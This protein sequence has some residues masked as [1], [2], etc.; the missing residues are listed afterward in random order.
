[1]KEKKGKIFNQQEVEAIIA[2]NKTMFR[3]VVKPLKHESLVNCVLKGQLL[4]EDSKK[5]KGFQV[6]FQK[7]KNKWFAEDKPTGIIVKSKFQVGQEIFVKENFWVNKKH[8]KFCWYNN[9]RLTLRIKSVKVESLQDI[10]EEDAIKEGMSGGLVHL[11]YLSEIDAFSAV[12]NSTHK[13]QEHK[14]EANPWVFV[15][16]FEVI[17]N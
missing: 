6:Y 17:N 12:W 9:S 2:G 13:K 14:W 5:V 3:E 15:Y 11:G 16:E 4:A 7:P 8:G 10:S 1:M